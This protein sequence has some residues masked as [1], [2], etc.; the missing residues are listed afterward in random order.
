[1]T[2]WRTGRRIVRKRLQD[3]MPK[4]Q[5]FVTTYAHGQ[6][7]RSPG[8]SVYLYSAPGL[9]PP[10]LL[11]TL[12]HNDSLHEQV[13]IVVVVTDPVPR[14]ALP[15]RAVVTD[16]GAGFHQVILHF[17]FMERPDVPQALRDRV[18]RKISMDMETVSY[19]IAREN[20]RVT[21]RPGMM[22]WREHLYALISRN[23]TGVARMFELPSDQTLEIGVLVEV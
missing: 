16:C 8:T 23:S 10:S 22:M 4:L 12:R 5:Q 17:G 3:R 1:M 6:T 11:A 20:L 13:L 19:V 14:V 18:Q 9:V 7:N 2:T 21:D 15:R